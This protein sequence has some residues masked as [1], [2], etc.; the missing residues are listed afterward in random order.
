M[1]MDLG[2]FLSTR[3]PFPG[4]AGWG[5]RCP[6]RT[7]EP[8]AYV[9]QLTPQRIEQL[10]ARLASGAE[11]VQ[12]HELKPQVMCWKFEQVQLFWAMRA[13]GTSL[14]LFVQNQSDASGRPQELLEEFLNLTL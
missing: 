6:R 12:S 4:L 9:P 1:N 5:V 14:A 13:D 7:I 2:T 3:L 8:K 10:I 11:A